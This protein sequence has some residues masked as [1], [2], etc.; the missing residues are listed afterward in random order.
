MAFDIPEIQPDDVLYLEN[1]Q[2]FVEIAKNLGIKE[3]FNTDYTST[4]AEPGSLG[5]SMDKTG[6][7]PCRDRD[8]SIY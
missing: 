1:T 5:L 3:I 6:I 8:D 4:C 7:Y 2:M